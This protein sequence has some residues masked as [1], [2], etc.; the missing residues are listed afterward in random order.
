MNSAMAKK[1]F[2]P[3]H[4]I[5][6]GVPM[7]Q[8]GP[9]AW[10]YDRPT[11]DRLAA[12]EYARAEAERLAEAEARAEVEVSEAESYAVL[13][14]RLEKCESDRRAEGDGSED[15]KVLPNGHLPGEEF[16]GM[17]AEPLGL[18]GVNSPP[19]EGQGQVGRPPSRFLTK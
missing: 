12:E 13:L 19:R 7:I 15:P 16:L 10:I 6:E 5:F 9:S 1:H 14:A 18:N 11:A 3:V 4:V 2:E 17:A 8:V